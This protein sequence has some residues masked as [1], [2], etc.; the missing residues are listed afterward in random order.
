[1]L[2]PSNKMTTLLNIRL[3]QIKRELN[4]AGPGTF[5]ILGG[6]WFLIYA[7]YTTYQKTPDAY[8]LTISLFF[9]C[10]SLQA[11]RKDKSFVYNHIDNPR[12]EIY[13]EY[14]VLTFPFAISSLLTINWFCYPLL[15]VALSIVPLLKYTLK[16]KSYFKNI[17]SIIPPSNFEW[18]SGFRKYFLYLIPLYVLAIG[19][20]WF[21]ILP[22]FLL[23]FM[24]IIVASFYKECEPLQIL[25]EG[26]LCPGKFLQ[27]KFFQHSKLMFFLYSPILIVNT[28]FN[29]EYWFVNLLF[30]PT[31][32]SLLCFSINLKYS[33]YQPNKN[34][35]ANNIM[36]SFVSLGSVIPY[37]LPIPVLLALE[38]YAKAK[39]NLNNYLND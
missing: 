38:Y 9:L 17:S 3:I 31:Q 18:I 34:P 5:L 30:I 21:R 24:T 2:C 32:I 8:F 10:L 20:C 36:L 14:I 28:I 27:Q 29:F 13:L 15:I 6:L 16:E 26:N 4:E 22:L 35:I 1:M 37:L 33:N 11:K 19:F 23:W 39:N 7:A 25:K 12:K